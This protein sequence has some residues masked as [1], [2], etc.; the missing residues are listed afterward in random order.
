MESTAGIKRQRESMAGSSKFKREKGKNGVACAACEKAKRKCSGQRPCERCA[1]LGKE[2]VDGSAAR[3]MRT[4]GK[5]PAQCSAKPRSRPKPQAARP[6][7]VPA[8]QPGY[9][10]SPK[11]Q[12]G[13][14]ASAPPLLAAQPAAAPELLTHSTSTPI[15][16][17]PYGL[18][19]SS[20]VPA[21]ASL[22]ASDAAGCD[23]GSAD[24][25]STLPASTATDPLL[26]LD[27]SSTLE[28]M[29]ARM[30]DALAE[31]NAEF[32]MPRER[33]FSMGSF[34]GPSS[35]SAPG[36]FG[37]GSPFS[38]L[39]IMFDDAGGFSPL[40]DFGCLSP[41]RGAQLP[42]AGSRLGAPVPPAAP[43]APRRAMAELDY[44]STRE[45]SAQPVHGPRQDI[46]LRAL[47]GLGEQMAGL[48]VCARASRAGDSSDRWLAESQ[49]CRRQ[50]L[51]LLQLP[52]GVLDLA[53]MQALGCGHHLPLPALA[54]LMRLQQAAWQRQAVCC[55]RVC[56]AGPE[57]AARQALQ[58]ALRRDPHLRCLL[59]SAAQQAEA[60]ELVVDPT[61]LSE[62]LASRARSS[63][64]CI[65][66]LSLPERAEL[67]PDSSSVHGLDLCAR[68][69]SA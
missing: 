28:L 27:P 42:G 7:H 31:F 13:Q 58:A 21:A 56:S 62:A 14:L 68:H 39:D 38:A 63:Q 6:Q 32:G 18:S 26:L 52:Q 19:I 2:C 51:R 3:R 36:S 29:G 1:R 48:H 24:A 16:V 37:T 30:P 34:A 57:A 22:T 8:C 65:T 55:S 4:T 54:K 33:S 60:A 5:L 23:T 59:G 50:R 47:D 69:E 41:V 45:D 66:G 67:A 20:E 40:L 12:A 46:A 64:C 44:N 43:A 15:F 53:A 9:E 17:E 10:S 49:R 25:G 61:Q 11:L 35:A